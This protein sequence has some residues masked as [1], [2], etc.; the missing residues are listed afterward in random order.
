MKPLSP[1]DPASLGR[2]V[3]R[4]TSY[5]TAPHFHEAV[6]PESYVRWLGSLGPETSLSL[7]VHIPFCDRLCWFCACRT[8][9]TSSYRPLERYLESV[10][11]EIEMVADATPAGRRVVHIHWGGGSPSVLTAEDIAR[12]SRMI[13]EAF[14]GAT[15]AEFAVEIDPRDMTPARLDA[16]AEAGVNRVSVGVQDF[17]PAVQAAI[18]R[19]QDAP[20]TREVIEGMRARGVRSINIDLLYGL[21]RQTEASLRRTIEAV[22]ALS[23]DRLAL[24]GYAHVPWMAR[25]QRMIDPAVLPDMEARRRQSDLARALM[26]E[27]GYVAVGIDH[28][29]RPGDGLV[30]ALEAGTLRRNFQGYTTDPGEAMISIG[31][32][33][34]GR[35]PQ[36]YVQ[37][38][39]STADYLAAIE[40]GQFATQR[41]RSLTLDDRIRAAVIEQLLCHFC[42]DISAL[43]ARFGDMAGP[44]LRVAEAL[45]ATAPEGTLVE[46][47][48]GFE[49]AEGW[50]N[51]AR[52]VAAEFDAYLAGGGVR[53]SVAL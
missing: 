48:T 51:H 15:D 5:P 23:P 26:L 33:A 38:R 40:E 29:A 50:R 46:T 20:L 39:V 6:G 27:A 13:A 49:I 42:L 35:M 2:S 31:A 43:R 9:G 18:G 19:I 7:Y 14:P 52:L 22:L 44:A 34:I 16:F 30:R 3:P 28:F 11:R 17:A 41:G 47:E 4:Y 8:Q 24:F 37:N 45:R 10:G 32:S 36:G 21:P 25:R 12:L 1:F 53:H